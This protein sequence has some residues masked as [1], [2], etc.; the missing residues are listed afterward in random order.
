[1]GFES[2]TLTLHPFLLD[3]CPFELLKGIIPIGFIFLAIKP[4]KIS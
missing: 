4:L 1:M 2:M 3:E